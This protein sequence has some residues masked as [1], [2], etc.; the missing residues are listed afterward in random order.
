MR[1][2]WRPPLLCCRYRLPARGQPLAFRLLALP[3]GLVVTVVPVLIYFVLPKARAGCC[4][5][6]S[7]KRRQ[8][9]STRSSAGPET[10]PAANGGRARGQLADHTRAAPTDWALFGRG[11]LRWTTVGILSGVCAGTAGFLIYVLLPKAIVD[12]GAAVTFS[13]GL[14]SLVYFASIP[15]KAFTGFLMEII[16]RRWTIAYALAGS[17]P[18]LFLMLIAHRWRIRDGRDGHGRADHRFHSSVGL[19]RHP[20]LPL[21]T[22]PDGAA[23][24]RAHLQ[25]VVGAAFRR[26][27]GA[28]FNGAA[29]GRRRSSSARFSSWWRSAPSSRCSLAARPSASS[30]P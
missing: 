19:H 2:G 18:G 16:G 23:R 10:V 15:G 5:K 17:L 30:K 3:G 24:P 26:R 6:A 8:T 27:A 25:R 28:V 14:S 13:F 11:Q 21:G 4:A 1:W 9:P 22:V 12:Q 29:I 20:G 7:R